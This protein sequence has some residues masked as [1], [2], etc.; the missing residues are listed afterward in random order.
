MTRGAPIEVI[1][2][3]TLQLQE[4]A[5]FRAPQRADTSAVYHGAAFVVARFKAALDP[6]WVQYAA[7]EA[8]FHPARRV[9]DDHSLAVGRE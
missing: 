6:S 1:R 5:S 2:Q 3:N 4:Q 7:E 9:T 8:A